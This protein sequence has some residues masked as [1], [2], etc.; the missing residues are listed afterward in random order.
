MKKDEILIAQDNVKA[1][2]N[3]PTILPDENK[4][5]YNPSPSGDPPSGPFGPP[6][7]RPKNKTGEQEPEE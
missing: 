6:R 4:T 1:A 7:P 5:G 3:I 2:I